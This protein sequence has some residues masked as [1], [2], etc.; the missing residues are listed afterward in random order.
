MG[1]A[2]GAGFAPNAILGRFPV[3]NHT[4]LFVLEARAFAVLS[5]IDMA[6]FL[7]GFKKKKTYKQ[8]R[9][10]K[11]RRNSRRKSRIWLIHNGNEPYQKLTQ[12]SADMVHSGF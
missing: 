1:N 5:A 11:L 6:P 7:F 9:Q 3:M 10:K 12:K 4:A 8:K 2:R